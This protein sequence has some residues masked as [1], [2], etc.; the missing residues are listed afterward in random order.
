MNRSKPVLAGVDGSRCSQHALPVAHEEAQLHEV[1]LFAVVAGPTSTSNWADG[2]TEFR[3]RVHQ[4][5][6]PSADPPRNRGSRALGGVRGK[7][8]GSV[9]SGAS[10]TRRGP[11]SCDLK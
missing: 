5:R 11:C 9:T 2:T 4:S 1:A 3:P 7:L 10:T 6:R 8:L